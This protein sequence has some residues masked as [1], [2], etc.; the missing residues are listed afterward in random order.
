MAFLF[1]SFGLGDNWDHTVVS[2]DGK[3]I[4]TAADDGYKE[5]VKYSMN[6]IKK[7]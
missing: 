3:V 6:C 4:F 1:G 2:N 7:A 5:G